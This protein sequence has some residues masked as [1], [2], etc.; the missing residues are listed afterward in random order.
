M[1][2]RTGILATI[3]LSLLLPSVA[4][5]IE[6]KTFEVPKG[7][8]TFEINILRGTTVPL[9]FPY[10]IIEAKYWSS[11]KFTFTRF[12]RG[13]DA[14]AP[15][16]IL[17]EANAE[18]THA[19]TTIWAGDLVVHLLIHAVSD[20]AKA[21]A[22]VAFVSREA[23]QQFQARVQ[24]AANKELA[25]H[26]KELESTKARYQEL[27]ANQVKLIEQRG[28]DLL[29]RALLTDLVKRKRAHGWC[30]VRQRKATPDMVVRAGWIRWIGNHLFVAFSIE[31][32]RDLSG[33]RVTLEPSDA[34]PRAMGLSFW[35]KDQQVMQRDSRGD[36]AVAGLA[37]AS[38]LVGS[39]VALRV[40]GPG[41]RPVVVSIRLPGPGCGVGW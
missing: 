9:A 3:A 13:G 37:N 16:M 5:A 24:R 15:K 6:A 28:Q 23:E 21:H 31:G 40:E 2:R 1:K 22:P 29:A 35:Q 26:L 14:D 11:D 36:L 4:N 18:A 19:Y 7:G 17:V 41:L 39:P 20:E 30:K 33:A 25:P 8:R 34:I 38:A 27:T 32:L 10:E 12:A